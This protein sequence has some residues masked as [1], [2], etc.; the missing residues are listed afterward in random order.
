MRLSAFFIWIDLEIDKFYS[1]SF[2][3][4][5][6]DNW[7]LKRVKNCFAFNYE[8]ILNIHNIVNKLWAVV[9]V[10]VVVIWGAI[11]SIFIKN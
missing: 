6:T 5:K 8:I 4:G 2:K 3:K 7:I 10:A 11:L 9:D 1:L